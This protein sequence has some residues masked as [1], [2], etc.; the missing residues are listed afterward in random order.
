[1]INFVSLKLVLVAFL[2][3]NF[4]SSAIITATF[5]LLAFV[6]VMFSLEKFTERREFHDVYSA[7]FSYLLFCPAPPHTTPPRCNGL[8]SHDVLVAPYMKCLVPHVVI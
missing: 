5:V 1:M 4:V 3:S 2:S 6:L 8:S 7:S